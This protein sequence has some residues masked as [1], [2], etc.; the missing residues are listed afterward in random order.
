MAA[1]AGTRFVEGSVLVV[2]FEPQQQAPAQVSLLVEEMGE[3]AIFD[4]A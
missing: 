2:D 3:T 4:S 1:A